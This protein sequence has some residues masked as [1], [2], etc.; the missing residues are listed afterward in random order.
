MQ[1]PLRH[2]ITIAATAL[3]I[4]SSAGCARAQ[5]S[6]V[7]LDV[8]DRA[9]A[10]SIGTW[11]K[12]EPVEAFETGHIYVVEFWATWCAPCLTSMPHLSQ[13]QRELG[14]QGV[15]VIGVTSP[16]PGNT[17]EA[18]EEMVA[19]KGD[20]MGYTVAWDPERRTSTDWMQAAGQNSIPTSFVVDGEGRIA[21]IGHP[22]W[23][24][25]PLHALLEGTWNYRTGPAEVA[26]AEEELMGIYQSAGSD[27]AGSLAGFL[28]FEERYPA[29]AGGMQDM[30][31]QLLLISGEFEAGYALAA[32]MT[33]EAVEK[34][35]STVLGMIAWLIVD[36]RAPFEERDLELALRAAEAAAELTGRDDPDILDT[37]ARVHAAKGDYRTAV[38]IQTRAVELAAGTRL[39]SNLRATLEEYREHIRG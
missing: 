5:Q 26:A 20:V 29:V 3:L 37:L 6:G 36:P 7:M 35:D 23:L 21:Y 27:P 13:I 10:L 19:E 38:S 8:G 34:G 39:E 11:V 32:R 16:D 12:G 14:E 24:D 22:M 1:V 2:S 31:L 30:K 15:T 4:I 25:M 28:S 17:L 18:V 33:D 9:P